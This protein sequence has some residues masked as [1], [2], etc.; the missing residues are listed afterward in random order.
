MYDS[1]LSRLFLVLS[2]ASAWGCTPTPGSTADES[3]GTPQAEPAAAPTAEPVDVNDADCAFFQA[4]V[5]SPFQRL[6]V[7]GVSPDAESLRLS[8]VQAAPN[9]RQQA[10][11]NLRAAGMLAAE[12]ADV[13][14]SS[15]T[16]P[17]VSERFQAAMTLPA[18]APDRAVAW[19]G[20]ALQNE[21]LSEDAITT[22]SLVLSWSGAE[23]LELL[24]ESGRANRPE[25]LQH[26]QAS[27]EFPAAAREHLFAPDAPC[28]TLPTL[29]CRELLLT[30]SV[31]Y[32]DLFTSAGDSAG[33]LPPVWQVA[34]IEAQP[35]T[36]GDAL[37][38]WASVVSTAP[39]DLVVESSQRLPVVTDWS[40]AVPALAAAIANAGTS[41]FERRQAVN[42]LALSNW[43]S[44]VGIQLLATTPRTDLSDRDKAALA[45]ALLAHGADR[46]MVSWARELITFA[47]DDSRDANLFAS[48]VLWELDMGRD[49]ILPVWQ[50]TES[51]VV[52]R[53][54]LDAASAADAIAATDR[55]LDSTHA[56][57]DALALRAGR[58]EAERLALIAAMPPEAP[59]TFWARVAMRMG[60]EDQA[61]AARIAANPVVELDA[62]SARWML[63]NGQRA[64]VQQWVETSAN[65]PSPWVRSAALQTALG[66]DLDVD[67][68]RLWTEM[69]GQQS[70]RFI[71]DPSLRLNAARLLGELQDASEWSRLR[72]QM[73]NTTPGTPA[74]TALA[75]VAARNA[76]RCADSE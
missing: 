13:V 41:A 51:W 19:A 65:D 52:A 59:H 26:V 21:E 60:A 64:F 23:G 53:D 33:E 36:D 46:E 32:P 35:F 7:G 24:A 73:E 38:R 70:T 2:L 29:S 18:I 66:A 3:S 39:S 11:V 37:A 9:A 50:S 10:W 69:T 55:V 28:Y 48:L 4:A 15:L 49:R 30:L 72:L 17:E 67:R 34:A 1:V 25:M 5:H 44:A 6:T 16:S 12:T 75:L 8:F 58:S 45:F 54:V 31:G 22:V 14:E 61:L 76:P 40:A 56:V 20:R 68:E 42:T 62:T 74:A 47:T 71:E 57:M 27:S 43:D 63:N